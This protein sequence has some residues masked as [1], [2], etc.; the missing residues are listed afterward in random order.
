MAYD[1]NVLLKNIKE[2]KKYKV[3][4]GILGSNAVQLNGNKTNAEIA[5]MQE[6]GDSALRI[7]ARSFLKMPLVIKKNFIKN[8][9]ISN[10]EKLLGYIARGETRIIFAKLGILSERIIQEAFATRGF[11]QWAPNSPMT[12]RLKGSDSP[13]IDTGQLR[14]SITSKV[15]P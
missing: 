12:I 4:I 2:L 11:G 1:P 13:L 7:P 15:I 3:K 8:N 6:F 5:Y 9:L 14:R 10:K